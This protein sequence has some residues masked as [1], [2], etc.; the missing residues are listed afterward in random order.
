MLTVYLSG[1]ECCA[2]VAGDR[3]GLFNADAVTSQFLVSDL[4]F[5]IST[6]DA[7]QITVGYQLTF[8]TLVFPYRFS[9]ATAYDT[10]RHYQALVLV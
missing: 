5:T 1:D 8:D 3:L 10:G 6:S 4:G 7:H 2:V 9:L